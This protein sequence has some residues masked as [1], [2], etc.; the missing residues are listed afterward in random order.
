VPIFVA[1]GFLAWLMYVDREHVIPA[2]AFAE[3]RREQSKF[4]KHDYL[5]P[6]PI[7]DGA[8]GVLSARFYEPKKKELDEARWTLLDEHDHETV[9]AI[10]STAVPVRNERTNERG[11]LFRQGVLVRVEQ[12]SDGERVR[13]EPIPA[14]GVLIR[15][16]LEP[17]DVECAIV[18][19][20]YLSTE[21]MRQHYEK[22]PF[23]RHL[24]VQLAKRFAYP[25]S[26][27]LLVLLGLPFVLRGDKTD[28]ASGVLACIGICALFFLATAFCEDMGAR[29]GGVH[30]VLAAWL[31]NIVFGLPGFASFLKVAR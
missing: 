28:A 14:S 9:S 13:V 16:E 23:L 2:K 30:P 25:C 15:T 5:I 22:C 11:W 12:A 3:L 24:G 17:L 26:S 21:Q 7:P 19:I 20:S 6:S 4:V 1:A 8:G 29:P 31:P 18:A 10:A 27:V